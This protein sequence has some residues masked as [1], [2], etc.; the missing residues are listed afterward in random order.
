MY[1][2]FDKNKFGVVLI[3]TR[4]VNPIP[5]VIDSAISKYHNYQLQV[6]E[7]DPSSESLEINND[8]M[9]NLFNNDSSQRSLRVVSED[10]FTNPEIKAAWKERQHRFDF[11]KDPGTRTFHGLETSSPTRG[12][13]KAQKRREERVLFH[14]VVS[15]CVW[16]RVVIGAQLNVSARSI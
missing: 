8:Q 12:N 16:S 10:T 5:F 7:A 6:L 13:L 9:Q 2:V 14:C 15:S 11:F 3:G 4:S 1:F